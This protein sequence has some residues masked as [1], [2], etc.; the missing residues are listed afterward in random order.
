MA[1]E[2]SVTAPPVRG[3][4]TGQAGDTPGKTNMKRTFTVLKPITL[5]YDSN[6]R[7]PTPPRYKRHDVGA[8]LRLDC[9][10]PNGNV[11]FVD[12][13]NERGKT[14]C[15]EVFNLIKTG[16]LFEHEG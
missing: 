15:G 1:E 6:V 14:E 11:W 9:E 8:S 12:S 10:A 2:G 13:D 5:G 16:H 3:T 7:R 4:V